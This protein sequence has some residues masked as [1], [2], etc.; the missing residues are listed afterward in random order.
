MVVGIFRLL[1]QI[2]RYF[3][4]YL[5]PNTCS[6]TDLGNVLTFVCKHQVQ[7][8]FSNTLESLQSEP[9]LLKAK[10]GKLVVRGA[11]TI[12]H[13]T[14]LGCGEYS[15]EH[16]KNEGTAQDMCSKIICG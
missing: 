4:Q 2:E 3:P 6:T 1:S 16:P 15:R 10:G 7:R 12:A 13:I 5:T 11:K 9:F 14:A 8:D